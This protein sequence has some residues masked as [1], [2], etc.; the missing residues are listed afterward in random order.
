M[1]TTAVDRQIF[2]INRKPCVLFVAIP[3]TRYL[4]ML[5]IRKLAYLMILD[6]RMLNGKH[7]TN[8]EMI[9]VTLKMDLPSQ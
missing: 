5:V 3:T 1:R 7:L 4:V 9:V 8:L 2:V 6:E